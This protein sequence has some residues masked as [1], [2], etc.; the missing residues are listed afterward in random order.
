MHRRL[1]ILT[2]VS[3]LVLTAGCTGDDTEFEDGN[4]NG[5][6]NGD[7]DVEEVVDI[8]EHEMLRENEGEIS[9]SVSVEG[10]AENTSDD[11]LS[12]VEI[13]VRFYDANGDLL[14]SGIDNINDFD[15]GQV[16][17]FEVSYLGFGD[18]AAEVDSYDIGVGT[19]F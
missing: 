11:R 1:F 19:S 8:L 17:R 10:R 13:R 16:W 15:S 4:G 18:D 5:D 3:S 7:P 9:E 2:A 6:G 12:Y 14:D